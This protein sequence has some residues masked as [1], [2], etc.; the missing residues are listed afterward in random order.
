MYRSLLLSFDG[1]ARLHFK[2]QR[3]VKVRVLY[4]YRHPDM[5]YSIGRVFKP[6]EEE[7]K[8]YAEVESFYLPVPNYSLKG[9][10]K[11]ICA[12]CKAVRQKHYDIVHITGAEHYLIPFLYG[13]KVVV[14]VHDLQSCLIKN[15]SIQS[16]IKRLLFINTL[17]YSNVITSI[18]KK[19]F[20]EVNE[21]IEMKGQK[22]FIVPNPINSTYKY[23]EKRFNSKQPTILHFCITPN[24]NLQRS[25]LALEGINIHLRIIGNLSNKEIALLNKCNTDYSNVSNLSD[26]EMLE[27]YKNCDIVGFP[28]YYEGFGMPIIE[29]N[30]IG[31]VVVTS[32]LEPMIDV[33]GNS[34]IL[35]DPLDI[36]S[37]RNGYVEAIANHDKYIQKGVRNVR[38]FRCDFIVQKYLYVYKEELANK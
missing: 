26:Q 34:A 12:A 5:G 6:I 36:D 25:I 9:L 37:I 38:R 24:K 19:T 23:Y 18:S 30:A 28:S 1:Y 3:F 14:T 31:R 21:M 11:N 7:M 27:E 2:Y 8:K 22:H 32:I 17:A 4:I 35:V 15:N 10:W 29:G 13:Q 16:Y 33:A 20:N